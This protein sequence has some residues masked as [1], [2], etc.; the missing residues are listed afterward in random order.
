MA[1][2]VDFLPSSVLQNVNTFTA[3]INAGSLNVLNVADTTVLG[4]GMLVSGNGINPGT[5]I[6]SIGQNSFTLSEEAK[7][8]LTGVLLTVGVPSYFVD[9][10]YN[11]IP[12]FVQDNDA[13]ASPINYP[14]YKFIWGMGSIVEKQI[15]FLVQSAT[16]KF[17]TFD[18]NYVDAPGWSQALDIDRC[19]EFALP[20]LAQFVGVSSESFGELN[21]AQKKDKITNRSGF[22]RGTLN[23]L[24]SAL[25]TEINYKL[26]GVTSVAPINDGQVVVMEQTALKKINFLG[27]TTTGNIITGIANTTGLVNGMYVYGSG[28][29]GNTTITNVT[30]NSI[31]LSHNS[32]STQNGNSFFATTGKAYTPDQYSIVILMPTVYFNNYTYATL[33]ASLSGNASITYSTID[34]EI[35]ALGSSGYQNLFLD[36]VPKSNSAFAPFIYKYRPAGVQVYVGGY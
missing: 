34:A 29:P 2:E 7:Q 1:S 19:P 36:A 5:I 30:S 3:N 28:I 13:Q 27:N 4:E 24:V 21:F 18:R 16:G 35:N 25:V 22:K 20:W 6:D 9:S 14:I 17:G 31:T 33:A 11:T 23:V 26:S 10:I 32:A 12:Q 8:N 15:N